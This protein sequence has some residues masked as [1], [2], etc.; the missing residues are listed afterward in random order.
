MSEDVF[1]PLP[2]MTWQGGDPVED[3]RAMRGR[4]RMREPEGP[5]EPMHPARVR[6]LREMLR[7]ADAQPA[8]EVPPLGRTVTPGEARQIRDDVAEEFRGWAGL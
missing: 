3:M 6:E 4:L 8:R 1:Q 7:S 5:Y 2:A